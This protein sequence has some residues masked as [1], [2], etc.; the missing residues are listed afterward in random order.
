MLYY[1][2]CIECPKFSRKF[3]DRKA[4]VLYLNQL[5]LDHGWSVKLEASKV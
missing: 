4:A 2:H 5:V 1:V 3:A